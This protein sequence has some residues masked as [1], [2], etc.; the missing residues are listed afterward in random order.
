MNSLLKRKNSLTSVVVAAIFAL[1]AF[2]AGTS[3]AQEKTV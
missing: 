3:V 1:G 2:T